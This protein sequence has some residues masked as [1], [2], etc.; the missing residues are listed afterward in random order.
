MNAIYLFKE[1]YNTDL[2]KFRKYK[3]WITKVCATYNYTIEEL[4]Y[5]FCSDKYLH[6]INLEYLNHDTYTDIITFDLQDD[7]TQSRDIMADIFISLERVTENANKICTDF[8]KE[9]AR[10]MIHG[11][12]HIIGFND[13]DIFAKSKMTLA[14]DKA[15]ELL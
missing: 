11:L 3:N 6:K 15:L 8:D 10:V 5:I 1:D 4:N 7:N 12:L 13:N 14:E 2:R 9:L